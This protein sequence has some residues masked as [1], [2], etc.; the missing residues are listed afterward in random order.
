[1]KRLLIPVLFAASL[2]GCAGL[3]GDVRP[4]APMAD[5]R[6]SNFVYRLKT[7]DQ[8]KMFMG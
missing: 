5:V 8:W 1:M 6:Q 2:S 7:L 3:R 4:F